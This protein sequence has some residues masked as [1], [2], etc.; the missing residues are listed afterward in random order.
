MDRYKIGEW[1]IECNQGPGSI[2]SDLTIFD[3]S[4]IS[5]QNHKSGIS[6]E[7]HTYE[8]LQLLQKPNQEEF[9]HRSGEILG[10]SVSYAVPEEGDISCSSYKGFVKPNRLYGVVRIQESTETIPFERLGPSNPILWST[11]LELFKKNTA[12]EKSN[13]SVKA[14]VMPDCFYSL[15]RMSVVVNRRFVRVLDTRIFHEFESNI[16]IRN[17]TVKQ[18]SFDEIYMKGFALSFSNNMRLDEELIRALNPVLAFT[19]QIII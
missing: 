11:E 6:Y 19:D 15:A 1:S 7:F 3:N 18:C 5:F 2:V 9:L 8:A 14:R 12:S 13:F 10:T 17:H 16:I 4:F